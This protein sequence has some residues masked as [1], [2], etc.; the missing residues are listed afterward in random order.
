MDRILLQ[1]LP[2]QVEVE[3][4]GPQARVQILS[5]VPIRGQLLKALFPEIKFPKC[6]RV[7]VFF[8][9]PLAQVRVFPYQCVQHC[10]VF[11]I[12]P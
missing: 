1:T 3:A 11:R 4:D 2:V 6:G 5:D 7:L 8:F 10:P 12:V 9:L